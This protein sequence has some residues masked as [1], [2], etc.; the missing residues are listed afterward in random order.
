M[1]GRSLLHPVRSETRQLRQAVGAA[2]PADPDEHVTLGIR[3]WIHGAEIPARRGGEPARPAQRLHPDGK[4]QRI[5]RDLVVRLERQ[6]RPFLRRP[7]SQRT[8]GDHSLDLVF[9]RA[10]Y[11]GGRPDHFFRRGGVWHGHGV[12]R[13]ARNRGRR[14]E[15]EGRAQSPS[16]RAEQR[17]HQ[18]GARPGDSPVHRAGRQRLRRSPAS[19]ERP[20]QLPHRLPRRGHA[21]HPGDLPDQAPPAGVPGHGNGL[22]P[23]RHRGQYARGL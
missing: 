13:R 21:R 14:Q 5:R 1:G 6:W 3:L 8:F 17:G 18:L 20:R 10:R 19:E 4:R 7:V 22:H 12:V 2:E 11:P 16:A 23:L 9:D 15:V